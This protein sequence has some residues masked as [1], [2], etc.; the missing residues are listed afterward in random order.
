MINQSK[1]SE[2]DSL[3]PQESGIDLYAIGGLGMTTGSMWNSWENTFNNGPVISL[4]LELPFTSSRIFALQLYGHTWFSKPNGKYQK[5]SDEYYSLMS[6][7]ALIK[8]YLYIPSEKISFSLH[9][10][11]LFLS[12][13]QEETGIDFGIG[14]NYKV[15]KDIMISAMRRINFGQPDVGGGSDDVPN[16]LMLEFSYKIM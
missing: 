11:Y 8:Y 6:L 16:Y 2:P 12:Q 3:D 1:A 7:S 13:N 10:G 9:L 5:V 15:N 4:G 14:L